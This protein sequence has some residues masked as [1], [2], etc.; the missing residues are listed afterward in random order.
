[1]TISDNERT[2]FTGVGERVAQLCKA[3]SS[4]QLHLA[5]VLGVSKQKVQACEVG[6]RRIPAFALR[7]LAKRWLSRSASVSTN[8][9]ARHDVGRL[10]IRVGVLVELVLRVH[11]PVEVRAS[12]GIR[13]DRI[14]IKVH[15]CQRLAISLLHV[16]QPRVRV[17]QM[18]E[19]KTGSVA[20]ITLA[21]QAKLPAASLENGK[22]GKWGKREASPLPLGENGKRPLYPLHAVVA[23]AQ[24]PGCT[25]AAVGAQLCAAVGVH[26]PAAPGVAVVVVDGLAPGR[27]QAVAD[28]KAVVLCAARGQVAAQVVTHGHVLAA[29]QAAQAVGGRV[30]VLG[31]RARADLAGGE[32]VQRVVAKLPAAPGAVRE[33]GKRPLYPGCLSSACGCRKRSSSCCPHPHRPGRRRRARCP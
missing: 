30:D 18:P 22:T 25:R 13:H 14:N 19:A 23:E 6:R 3:R 10:A 12:L 1:M 9:A 32:V 11:V 26:H 4:T 5:V 27:T 17:V 33:K 15:P 29:R 31:Q 20:F 2:F 7:L 16:H 24:L 8:H 28:V 21:R